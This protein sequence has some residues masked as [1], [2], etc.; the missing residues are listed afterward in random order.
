MKHGLLKENR[1]TPVS[2]AGEDYDDR[3]KSSLAISYNQKIVQGDAS[4]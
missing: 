2:N 3:N 4:G 1:G